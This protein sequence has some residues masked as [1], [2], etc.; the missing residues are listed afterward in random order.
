MDAELGGPPSALPVLPEEILASDQSAEED[1]S[2]SDW[3]PDES[4]SF[5]EES[6]F[7]SD[8]LPEHTDV[9]HV[10][11]SVPASL[12]ILG[13]LNQTYERDLGADYVPES[14]M[15]SDNDSVVFPALQ[16]PNQTSG[17]DEGTTPKCKQHCCKFCM[18][19]NT[20]M[21]THLQRC[22]R[23]EPE[24]ALIL[25]MKTCDR[26]RR[27]A[28]IKLQDEGDFA[29]NLKVLTEKDG[30][31]IQKY[32]QKAGPR[33]ATDY[34]ACQYCKGLFLKTLLSKHDH[35]CPQKPDGI[36]HKRGQCAAQARMLLPLP[37]GM[38]SVFFEKV[39]LKMKDDDIRRLVQ[40]DSL[41]L[42]YGERLFSRR[43]IEEHSSGQIS[44]RLRE[45][46]RL[47][48]LLRRHSVMKGRS[49]M[50]VATLARAI[51]PSNFDLLIACVKELGQFNHSTNM[52]KKGSLVLKLG[53]SLKKCSQ[54]L[55]AEAIKT[56]DAVSKD[57]CDRF[58]SLYAGD[59]F[60]S[61]S[62]CASQ[63]VQRAKM[64][65]PKLLPSLADVEKVNNV[66][67]KDLQIESYPTL[68][69]ATLASI[70][71][72]NRKRGGEVQRMKCT[73]FAKS[74]KSLSAPEEEILAELT[75][76]EK[77][78]VHKLQRVEIRG[79]F[80]RPVPILLTPMMV[81]SI[82]KLLSFRTLLGINSDYL[83]VTPAG[84][85]PYRGPAVLKE[86]AMK[87]AVTDPSLFTA[88]ALRKQLA[89]LSQAMEVS[90]LNQD[91][92]AAFLGHDIRVHRS[93]YRQPLEV[94]QKAKVASILFKVN[95]GI[96][97]T[98]DCCDALEEAELE[99][100]EANEGIEDDEEDEDCDTEL[101]G[102]ESAPENNHSSMTVP[103]MQTEGSSPLS[104]KPGLGRTRTHQASHATSKQ[105]TT[106]TPREKRPWS[107]DEI[108]AVKKHLHHCIILNKVPQ[109][110]DAELA[111][112][113]EPLLSHRNWKDLKYCVYN[114]LKKERSQN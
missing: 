88:T 51:D 25:K 108:K 82:E 18:K 75:N 80:N 4:E 110:H 72:F 52:C 58:Q 55:Q 98:D 91:Q 94:M 95:K 48:Q 27:T 100:E 26:N 112:A 7:G 28:F 69:K 46:G 30:D 90:K 93:V 37:Q 76:T 74:K 9:V 96:Q 19:M 38:T 71:I 89:T 34:L 36:M 22:H 59:W 24:V 54:I 73:D 101:Q 5:S 35:R 47:L 16:T 44:G 99:L 23:L 1:D 105:T 31:L 67:Q 77:K 56:D 50:K 107:K 111:L 66:I 92:L 11:G 49:E 12:P 17:Q 41:I 40:A 53:Y 60:D 33:P 13:T 68:A 10:T 62:A 114:L 20:K 104:G 63:S 14:N 32:K 103:Q 85:K 70:T 15:E 84:L 79:K 3:L 45:L 21:S 39:I 102:P 97:I 106:R 42:K 109:K 113:S 83:F 61:V 86:Y 29:H 2:A 78:L 57:K 64:N 65:M 87:A 8:F 81:Q 43:D 6:E